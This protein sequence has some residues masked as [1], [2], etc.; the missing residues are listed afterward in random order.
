MKTYYAKPGDIKQEWFVVDL[1]GKTV[2]RAATEI[3]SVLRGKHKPQFTPNTD[4]GDFVIAINADK[5]V[6]TGKKMQRKVYFWHTGYFGG[7]KSITAAKQLQRKPEEIISEAVWGMIPKGPLG[8]R[9][10][11]KFKVYAGP[12]HPHAAQQPK[13]LEV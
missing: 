13:V 12:E 8:R 7:I 11:K 10:F 2:G 4:S 1:A 9:V 5:I 3:A 6:F